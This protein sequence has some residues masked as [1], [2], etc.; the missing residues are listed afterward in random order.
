MQ[1]LQEIQ[2]LCETQSRNMLKM[3]EVSRIARILHDAGI[4]LDLE[5]IAYYGNMSQDEVSRLV[6]WS[7]SVKKSAKLGFELGS[8]SQS[9]GDF[10]ELLV[11]LLFLQRHKQ[12]GIQTVEKHSGLSQERIRDLVANHTDDIKKEFSSFGPYWI[13]DSADAA[14]VNAR[15]QKPTDKKA[16]IRKGIEDISRGRIGS[17]SAEQLEKWNSGAIGLDRRAIDN[18]LSNDPELRDLDKYRVSGRRVGT[19]DSDRQIRFDRERNR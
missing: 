4:V 10:A 11:G 6:K 7:E 13:R 2:L 9:K 15:R 3:I 14:R 1:L 12:P 19:T 8:Q 16:L 5:N 17:V 18:Y